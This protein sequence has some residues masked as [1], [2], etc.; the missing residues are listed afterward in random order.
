MKVHQ[1]LITPS[2]TIYKANYQTKNISFG[3][4]LETT[5]SIMFVRVTKSLYLSE[6]V[7][8]FQKLFRTLYE[9]NKQNILRSYT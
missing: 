2:S 7:I 5:V 1:N 9:N 6:F 3:E 8:V 4:S